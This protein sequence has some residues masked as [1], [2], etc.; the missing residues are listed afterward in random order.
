M[1]KY[2]AITA[3]LLMVCG[4]AQARKVTGKVVSGKEK[5][6][7]VIV[8]DGE[9]FT[10]TKKNGTFSFEINDD[11]EFVYIVTPAGYA[12]DWSSGVPAFYQRA[13]GK[14]NFVFDLIETDRSGNYS[15]IT[16]SDPQTKTVKHISQF[17]ATPVEELA[18][19]A[20]KLEGAVVGV[21]L[22]DVLWDKLNLY[23][24]YKKEIVRTGIPFYPVPGNHDHEL[25]AQGDIRTTAIYRKA[26]GPEN[27]A[28]YLGKDLVIALDN[29]IYDTQKKYE[30]GYA[31]HVLA[32]VAGLM[33]HVSEDT[34]L[35]VVQHGTVFRW[36]EAERWVV[37]AEEF[38]NIVRGHKVTFISGH[39][40]ISN[41]MNYEENIVEHNIPAI[42]GSWWDTYYCTDGS[43]SGYKVYTSKDGKVEW[44]YKS[45][46]KDKD[47]Q[48]EFFMPGETPHNAECVVANVWDW[49]PEWKVE[50][51]ED[52]KYMGVLD[53]TFDL[54]PNYIADINKAFQGKNIPNY[55]KPRH[56]WHYFAAKPGKDAKTVK[57]V[58]TSRFGQQW[59]C[60]VDMTRYAGQQ[61]ENVW[62]ASIPENAVQLLK[63]AGIF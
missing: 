4:V 11:A 20:S 54:S 21:V 13:E 52:G 51:Y 24:D 12:A 41:N 38:F 35:Y 31:P 37:S 40:H 17:A 60:E 3:A 29:I 22:G 1:R 43:P 9:N 5:L 62:P 23:D 16:V 57:M 6:Q 2:L 49:D 7:K 19:T 30:E 15:M 8:T 34:D 14:D 28:F 25:E 44:Y 47:Y 55:K 50:W 10:Q 58:V 48:V 36:F 59:E 63:E 27:Y 46:G 45:L 56:N 18:E 53:P 42:C 32:W 26:M 39:T 61:F 33:E